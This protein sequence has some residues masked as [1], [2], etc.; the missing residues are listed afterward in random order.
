MTEPRPSAEPQPAARPGPALEAEIVA[1]H[2]HLKE[3]HIRQ[4]TVLCDEGPQIGGTDTAPPPLG[5]FTLAIG[6]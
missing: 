2:G 5:Y 3:G 4:F 1:L 6:F